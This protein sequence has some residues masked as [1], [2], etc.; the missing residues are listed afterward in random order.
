MRPSPTRL[1]DGAGGPDG[2]REVHRRLVVVVG[3]HPL[4][5]PEA[6][7]QQQVHRE[8]RLELGEERHGPVPLPGA[9][10]RLRPLGLPAHQARR[11]RHH[12]RHGLVDGQGVIDAALVEGEV[13]EPD[14]P[15][16]PSLRLGQVAQQLGRLLARLAI[17]DRRRAEGE[18]AGGHRRQLGRVVRLGEADRLDAGGHRRRE[19]TAVLDHGSG[20][21]H[22]DQRPHGA[23]GAEV[24]V[25]IVE[26]GV[27]RRRPA[28]EGQRRGQHLGEEQGVGRQPHLAGDLQVAIEQRLAAG[29]APG[30]PAGRRT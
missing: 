6:V 30:D 3:Q 25:E 1:P 10:H 22:A 28:Q 13:A 5:P 7:G 20:A 2:R 12:R 24:A 29:D 8:R 26:Q 4:R 9:D 21:E 19:R 23:T 15:E 16:R 27:G 17:A 11:N 14:R 18:D